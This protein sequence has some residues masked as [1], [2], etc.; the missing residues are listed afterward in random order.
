MVALTIYLVSRITAQVAHKKEV[1]RRRS[2]E[3]TA[4]VTTAAITAIPLLMKSPLMKSVGL[5]LGAA[6]ASLFILSRSRRDNDEATG[7]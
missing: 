5:P 6:L 4:L 7:E 2:S 1:Q 3:T